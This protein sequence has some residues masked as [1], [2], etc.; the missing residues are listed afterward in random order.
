[1]TEKKSAWDRASES[2][3]GR[4][5]G[6]VRDVLADEL[7]SFTGPKPGADNDAWMKR[8][9]HGGVIPTAIAEGLADAIDYPRA[10]LSEEKQ[11]RNP[12][13]SVKDEA[14]GWGLETGTGMGLTA[15]AITKANPAL[16]PGD[17]SLGV[18]IGEKGGKRIGKDGELDIA[19]KLYDEGFPI[20]DIRKE[21]NWS[22]G[23]R[24]EGDW[25]FEISDHKSGFKPDALVDDAH[26]YKGTRYGTI[27]ENY[28]HPELF[29][30]YPDLANVRLY[31]GTGPRSRGLFDSENASIDVIGENEHDLRRILGHELQ[32][33]VDALEKKAGGSSPAFTYA[34]MEMNKHE[35]PEAA[36][37]AWDKLPHQQKMSMAFRRYRHDAGEVNAE[38]TAQSMDLN[39]VH[40]REI[41]PEMRYP[42]DVD[43]NQITV[44]RASAK[45]EPAESAGPRV[46]PES[47]KPPGKRTQADLPDLRSM[48][49][50]K[51]Y[52]HANK[53]FA[54]YLDKHTAYAT[55]EALPGSYTGHMPKLQAAD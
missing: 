53:T 19:K 22:F 27:G 40:R 35:L 26:G 29:Q 7:E 44:G 30:A 13:G 20:E 47:A 8:R 12:D 18:F 38:T 9:R 42:S 37:K 45:Y 39:E 49:L 28:D 41:P 4:A 50:E 14:V 54:D 32:H 23:P 48:E 43:P 24:G 17:N 33:G 36:R 21:T 46:V 6:S 16:G 5:I 55:H 2:R 11:I 31:G 52:K 3:F 10:L 51:A 1:M 15:K 34:Q 25:Q